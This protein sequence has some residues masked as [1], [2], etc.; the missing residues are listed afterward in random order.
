MFAISERSLKGSSEY[1]AQVR[2]NVSASRHSG[3]R[4]S[5]Y[6]SEWSDPVYWTTRPGL[7]LITLLPTILYIFV[8]QYK[9]T[10]CIV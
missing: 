5:G 3:W 6:P 2:C 8:V 1:H 10:S 9:I 4:Y 7:R